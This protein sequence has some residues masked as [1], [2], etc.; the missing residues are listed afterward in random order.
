MEGVGRPAVLFLQEALA[1][2]G[3]RLTK[4]D[5]AQR[6]GSLQEGKEFQLVRAL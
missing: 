1:H 2:V 4:R 6:Q 5:P 3:L